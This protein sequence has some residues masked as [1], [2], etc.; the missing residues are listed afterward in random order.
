MKNAINLHEISIR[1]FI[2]DLHELWMLDRFE[3][4]EYM[5]LVYAH[6]LQHEVNWVE[7]ASYVSEAGELTDRMMDP[8]DCFEYDINDCSKDSFAAFEAVCMQLMDFSSMIQ[9]QRR[10][11]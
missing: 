7:S 4:Q 1:T 5:N 6:M 3:M 8:L 10:A 9:T 2:E 11:A